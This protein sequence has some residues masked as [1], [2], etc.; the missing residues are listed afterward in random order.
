MSFNV[1]A[2]AYDQFM[3]AWSGPLS[4][5]FADFAGIKPGMRV[6]DVGCGPGSLTAELVARV[7]AGVGADLN[8]SSF[9][10]SERACS[11]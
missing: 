6:L 7:G 9:S 5:T 4:S 1:A 10:R 11:W 8:L 2:E 3:G